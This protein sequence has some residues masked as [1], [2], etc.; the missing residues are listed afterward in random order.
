VEGPARTTSAS[1]SPAPGPG[2]RGPYTPAMTG[3]TLGAA[4]SDVDV[5]AR[6]LG[7]AGLG[8]AIGGLL[9]TWWIWYRSG[10]QIAVVLKVE[11][12]G[13]R[14]EWTGRGPVDVIE[15]LNSGRSSA[16]IREVQ[17]RYMNDGDPRPHHVRWPAEFGGFPVHIPPTGFIS[18]IRPK[19]ETFPYRG[20]EQVWG[21]AIEGAEK[22]HESRRIRVSPN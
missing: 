15:V 10:P 13:E 8:V 20:V 9:L 12:E 3:L 5:V 11:V 7:I 22:K 17:I 2:S 14:I 6:T 21:C 19:D 18:A 4:A 1:A 16:A